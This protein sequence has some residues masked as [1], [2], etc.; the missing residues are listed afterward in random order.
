MTKNKQPRDNNG[1]FTKKLIKIE[2]KF[3]N[4]AYFTP[5]EMAGFKT[6]PKNPD[7]DPATKG[8]V[9][10]LMR[11]TRD[12]THMFD[13]FPFFSILGTV[14][15]TAVTMGFLAGI[16]T[17]PGFVAWGWYPPVGPSLAFT[18]ACFVFFLDHSDAS[19]ERIRE[20]IPNELLK[21]TPPKKDECEE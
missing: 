18:L 16:G 6:T 19:I 12:H 11:K 14:C 21:Y 3:G 20:Q 10:D 2:D 7:C 8:Y 15:G 9:K 13:N 1:K 5:E 4:V 17:T